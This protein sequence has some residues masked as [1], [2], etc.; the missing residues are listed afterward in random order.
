[1]RLSPCIGFLALDVK[2]IRQVTS[3]RQSFL[4]KS[5]LE[6]QMGE[7]IGAQPACLAASLAACPFNA[8]I[9]PVMS[10]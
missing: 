9:T 3:S 6:H 7:C 4:V 5:C 1:M 2:Y 8:S 10:A